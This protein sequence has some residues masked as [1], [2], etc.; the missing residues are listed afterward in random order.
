M[1]LD[2]VLVRCRIWF[3]LSFKLDVGFSFSWMFVLVLV[4]CCFYFKFQLEIVFKT[5]FIWHFMLFIFIRLL[6]LENERGTKSG[7]TW[8]WTHCAL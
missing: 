2:L 6:F 8:S 7:N 1:K 5:D 3:C 4:G